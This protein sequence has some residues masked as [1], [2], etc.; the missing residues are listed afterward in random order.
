VVHFLVLHVTFLLILAFFILF[1]ASKADGFVSLLGR[2]LAAWLFLLAVLHI[3]MHFAPGVMGEKGMAG[4]MMHGHWMHHWDQQ[5][6]PATP[7]A[8]PAPAA[9]APATPA[10]PKKP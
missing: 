7:A 1:A 3:V 2:I 5:A 8:V 10:S 9:P 4:G 6:T